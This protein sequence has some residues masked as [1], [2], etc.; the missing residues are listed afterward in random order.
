MRL[1]RI[2]QFSL[3]TVSPSS[4]PN[5][6]P[7]FTWNHSLFWPDFSDASSAGL[8]DKFFR[9]EGLITFAM[10]MLWATSAFHF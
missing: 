7:F 3:E 2:H 10:K 9:I 1:W 4:G 5:N 8:R 6:I